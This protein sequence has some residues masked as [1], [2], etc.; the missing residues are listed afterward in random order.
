MDGGLTWETIPEGGRGIGLELVD[1]AVFFTNGPGAILSIIPDV[2]VDPEGWRPP[3]PLQRISFIDS[4]QG[5]ATDTASRLWNTRDGGR[6]WAPVDTTSTSERLVSI[7]FASM[8]V[9]WAVTPSGTLLRT[10]DGG[11]TWSAGLGRSEVR[12]VEFN[13][14]R[15]GW[16]VGAQGLVLHTTD[17]GKSWVTT[18][19]PGRRNLIAVRFFAPDSGIIVDDRRMIWRLRKTDGSVTGW[20]STEVAGQEAI[21]TGG[22]ASL[23]DASADF[24]R[25]RTA[26]GEVVALQDGVYYMG[27]SNVVVVLPEG[28]V[29]QSH[30]NGETWIDDEPAT[31]ARLR[32]L[33]VGGDSTWWG[34]SSS[35]A[36]LKSLD[37][38]ASWSDPAKY[39]R[40]PAPWYWLSF[41]L[42]GALLTPVMRRPRPPPP[43]E[44][45]A[46]L[47]VSDRPLRRGDPDALDLSSVAL[48]LSRFIRNSKTEPPLTIAITG[49]W[50]TGKSSLMNLLQDDL[51]QYGFR[52]IWFNAWH[53]QKEEH[54]LASLLHKVQTHAVPPLFHRNG[55]KFRARL[56][57][58]R[59]DR[60]RWAALILAVVVVGSAGYLASDWREQPQRVFDATTGLVGSVVSAFKGDTVPA[61]SQESPDP[62]PPPNR[63]SLATPPDKAERPAEEKSLLA[64]LLLLASGSATLWKGLRAFGGVPATLM[65]T[66]RGAFKLK[67]LKA[68]TGFRSQFESDFREVTGAL[69]AAQMVILID[70]LDRC[71]PENVLEV[72]EAINF[73]VSSGDCFVVLGMDRHFVEG[74]VGIGFKHV[75][76]ELAEFD[77]PPQNSGDGE[78]GALTGAADRGRK[79][80]REFAAQYLE[81]LI[82]IEVPVPAASATQLGKIIARPAEVVKLMD[83]QRTRRRWWTAAGR[84]ALV[85]L[86]AGAMVSLFLWSR[87]KG[88]QDMA[89]AWPSAAAPAPRP[90]ASANDDSPP[91]RPRPRENDEIIGPPGDLIPAEQAPLS[92]LLIVVSVV[93]L[94]GAGLVAILRQPAVTVHDS[95]SFTEALNVWSPFLYSKRKTPRAMKRFLNRVRFYAMRQQAHMPVETLWDRICGWLSRWSSL[96]S[97]IRWVRSDDIAE[98]VRL[99]E[100]QQEAEAPKDSVDKKAIPEDV[101]VALTSIRECRADWLQ[102]PELFADFPEFL[103]EVD[104]REPLP[105]SVQREMQDFRRWGPLT[106]YREKFLRLSDSVRAD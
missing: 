89:A 25:L 27:E 103:E 80:R 38:G 66:V 104:E 97:A 69:G 48:G 2:D 11:V 44:S 13:D 37:K 21:E 57:W 56:L 87:Q 68:Q 67:D 94:A 32:S 22:F 33:S 73:L 42:V 74:C 5:W 23:P 96:S 9:G 59:A 54:L 18:H 35:G 63:D 70:D 60:F 10:E 101:L 55:L 75:A 8:R 99:A 16:A 62:P 76:E 65:T 61:N 41:L 85:V 77:T 46:D 81:K 12:E 105:E 98:K 14:A 3:V 17:G 30:D 52:P 100:Q 72:L 88:Y 79:I 45:V 71:K 106:P 64:L 4:Q 39:K 50:G 36:V 6:T 58:Y 51:R 43:T 31:R 28:N 93:L 95:E 1:S 83:R 20:V 7:S 53:H 19:I 26:A 91:A 24:E 102:K 84:A 40:T 78:A 47:L 15:N 49:Q 34:V 82:N 92:S 29:K 90:V 86:A